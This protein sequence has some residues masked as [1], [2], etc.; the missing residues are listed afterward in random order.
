MSTFVTLVKS[1][2]GGKHVNNDSLK[3]WL[4]SDADYPGFKYLTEEEIIENVEGHMKR[5]TISLQHRHGSFRKHG[6]N[7]STS[8]CNTG[9]STM[10]SRN[11]F[12]MKKKI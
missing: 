3:K 12:V 6:C 7:T 9:R 5:K 4:H 10:T 1:V 11:I 8:C 2:I